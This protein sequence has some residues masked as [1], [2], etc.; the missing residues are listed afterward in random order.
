MDDKRE[1][2]RIKTETNT[3]E[4]KTILKEEGEK[5]V[6]KINRVMNMETGVEELREMKG[7][8][9]QIMANRFDRLAIKKEEPWE[10]L[11]D[12][13]P[14]NFEKTMAPSTQ[15]NFLETLSGQRDLG[16]LS[17]PTH[18]QSAQPISPTL[19][20]FWTAVAVPTFPPP[21]LGHYP[22]LSKSGRDE[23]SDCLG[24]CAV[25]SNSPRM[26][27]KTYP[28]RKTY[29]FFFFRLSIFRFDE[30]TYPTENAHVQY[31]PNHREWKIRPIS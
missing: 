28:L 1:G 30:S 29:T 6:N 20:S 31:F 2:D 8:T 9:Q 11:G 5:I 17:D 26:E 24:T 21:K 27:N 12:W 16:S 4:L 22:T 15:P 3:E 19:F 7:E 14:N 18:Y 13:R 23:R 25:L 10:Q